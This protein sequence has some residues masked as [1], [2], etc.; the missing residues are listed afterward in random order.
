MF[1]NWKFQTGPEYWNKSP[2]FPQ[3][4]DKYVNMKVSSQHKQCR[5]LSLL[6]S[7]MRKCIYNPKS[8]TK[9]LQKLLMFQDSRSENRLVKKQMLNVGK[10]LLVIWR[11]IL[12]S[13]TIQIKY[14][15][16][17]FKRSLQYEIII[18]MI[19]M[20]ILWQLLLTW[21]KGIFWTPPSTKAQ[22]KL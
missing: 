7:S 12:H 14:N 15:K 13:E 20:I 5:A 19:N 17:L 4:R 2:F 11:N 3:D 16:L 8:S 18:L 6:Y 22:G 1:Q 21:S 10:M 9:I